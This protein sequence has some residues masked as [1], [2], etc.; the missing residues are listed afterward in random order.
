[1]LIH[2]LTPNGLPWTRNGVPKT[3]AQEDRIIREKRA[4]RPEALCRGLPDV[5]EDFLRYCKSLSFAERPDYNRWRNELAE[6]ARDNGWATNQSGLVDDAFYWPPRPTDVVSMCL[7]GSKHLLAN[8]LVIR[9]LLDRKQRLV[10]LQCLLRSEIQEN[11]R[12]TLR[13]F[14]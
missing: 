5:F 3:A 6:L 11:L 7:S 4:A 12:Q 1:M 9:P 2:L 10:Q 8:T 13:S 14:L